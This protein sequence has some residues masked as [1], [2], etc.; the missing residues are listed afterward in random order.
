MT[1]TSFNQSSGTLTSVQ[2]FLK[3]TSDYTAED[4]PPYFSNSLLIHSKPGD[5]WFFNLQSVQIYSV[6]A[7]M[8]GKI[9]HT[10]KKN[11]MLQVT[12]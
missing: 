11:K 1:I 12:G 10:Q 6:S 7:G 8:T 3:I 9:T 2:T 5:V 4:S